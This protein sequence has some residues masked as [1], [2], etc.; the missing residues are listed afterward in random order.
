LPQ[1]RHRLTAPRAT[2]ERAVGAAD[3]AAHPIGLRTEFRCPP[4]VGDV[5]NDSFE[6]FGE[7]V[8]TTEPKASACKVSAATVLTEPAM[9]YT[10]GADTVAMEFALKYRWRIGG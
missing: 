4:R 1:L 6:T 9:S 10:L 5:P 8:K 7:N 3:G 2:L